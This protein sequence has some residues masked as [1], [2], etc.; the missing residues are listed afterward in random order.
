MT[1]VITE[2]EAKQ[3]ECRIAPPI[4]DD[5]LGPTFAKCSGD[6]CCHWR[7]IPNQTTEDRWV[8]A[9]RRCAEAIGDKTRN[10]A[11]AA[12]EIVKNPGKWGLSTKPTHGYCGLAGAPYYIKPA[13]G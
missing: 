1:S 5:V 6:E 2:Y 4:P 9:M 11:K 13:K 7:W 10:R 8:E 12:A 3:K